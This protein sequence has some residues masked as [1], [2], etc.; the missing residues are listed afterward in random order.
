MKLTL[1]SLLIV[2]SSN[3]IMAQIS[4][5]EAIDLVITEIM[6]PGSLQYHHLY[7]KYDKMYLNDTLWLDQMVDFY[8]CPYNENWVFFI[9][10]MPVVHWAHPCRYVFVDA[11]NADYEIIDEYWPPHPFLTNYTNFFLEWEW[12]VS[13]HSNSFQ[14]FHADEF[15]ITVSNPF[16]NLLKISIQSDIN[17]LLRFQ[18]FDSNGRIVLSKTSDKPLKN[19]MFLKFNTEKMVAGIYFLIVSSDSQF[20][21]SKK[22]LKTN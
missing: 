1:C 3:F 17:E 19:E 21:L 5:E 14:F 22:L 11:N 15:I 18:L 13:T 6:E 9:D 2:L 8:L 4:R 12:I 7:S 10:D 20:L 16:Q